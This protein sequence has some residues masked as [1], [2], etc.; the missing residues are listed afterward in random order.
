MARTTDASR[1]KRHHALTVA[2]AS[3]AI[4]VTVMAV[5]LFRLEAG[6]DPAIGTARANGSVEQRRLVVKRKVIQIIRDAPA[7]STGESLGGG[8]YSA[9]APQSYSAPAPAPAPS[10][11]AS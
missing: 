10:T 6:F 5:L 1:Q 3:I 11:S 8:S 9:P 7:E 4:F 2:Y